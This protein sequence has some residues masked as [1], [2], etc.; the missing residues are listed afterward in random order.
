LR[1]F[2]A[3]IAV[4]WLSLTCLK[5]CVGGGATFLV[6]LPTASENEWSK[7]ADGFIYLSLPRTILKAQSTKFSTSTYLK[8]LIN[9][10]VKEFNGKIYIEKNFPK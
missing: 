9:N 5:P 2:G 6:P 3:T 8:S 1:K 4:C 7:V 10:I